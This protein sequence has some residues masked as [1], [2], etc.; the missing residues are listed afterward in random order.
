M[1]VTL[2]LFSLKSVT[3]GGSAVTWPIDMP[4]F[5]VVALPILAV[6]WIRAPYNDQRIITSEAGSAIIPPSAQ[7]GPLGRPIPALPWV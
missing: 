1:G 7:E 2:S 5:L 6:G 4:R 3:A